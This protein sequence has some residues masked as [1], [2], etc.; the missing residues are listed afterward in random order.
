M[1]KQRMVAKKINETVIPAHTADGIKA[2]TYQYM[3]Q[4]VTG[5]TFYVE[6]VD[7]YGRTQLHGPF[8][9]GQ[10]HGQAI[11][12]DPIDWGSILFEHQTKEEA[13]R[14][15]AVANTQAQMHTTVGPVAHFNIT[16]DGLYRVSY[17]DLLNGGFDLSGVATADIAVT[18]WDIPVPLH[19]E[20]GATFEV[21]SYIEFYG[22]GV[23][24]TYTKENVYT[25]HIDSALANRVI[26]DST[27]P[28]GS[29]APFYMETLDLGMNRLYDV[30]SS[31]NTPWYDSRLVATSGEVARSFPFVVDHYVAGVA[32]STLSIDMWG[33]TQFEQSPD[34]HVVVDFGGTTLADVTFDGLT[35]HPLYMTL[36]D[37]LVQEGSN[38]LI[39]R[40]PHDQGVMWDV[41]GVTSYDLTYPRAF[42][43]QDE[44]ILIFQS[45]GDMFQIEDL[46]TD[47]V[48]VYRLHGRGLVPQMTRLEGVVI[49]GSSGDYQA[50]FP[51]TA[52]EDTYLVYATAHM[53][54]PAIE[55]V[56]AYTDITSGSAD[57]LMIAHPDFVNDLAPLVS[58]H[59]AQGLT[60]QVVDVMDIYDQFNG[61]VVD[62]WAIKEYIKY[63]AQNMGI[64]YV[65]LVGGDS[66]DYHNYLGTGA[67]SF[68]PTIYMRTGD[69]VKFAPT[70]PFY[71]DID[72]DLVPDLK[73]GRFPVR[74]S[75]ELGYVIQKTIT[76]QG[77][78][79][80]ETAI[81]AADATDGLVSFS[82]VSDQL[83][84]QLST[85]QVT[86]AYLDDM[87]VADAQTL[88]EDN[89]NNGVALVNFFGHSS[90]T[91]W[92][93][94]GL[95][96]ASD[97]ALLNN[98]NLPTV[99]AQWGCWNTYYVA[100]QYNTMGHQFMMAGEQG[101]A[102]V[103]GASTLTNATHEQ[104][105]GELVLARL[106][107]P[108]TTLGE[109]ITLAK[110]DLSA[111]NPG[112]IDV[113]MGYSLLG[114]PALAMSNGEPTAVAMHLT[115][116]Q[117]ARL[118]LIL[119]S[120]TILMVAV[121][122]MVLLTRRR[123]SIS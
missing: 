10:Q 2:N 37:G 68:I 3:A 53:H 66:Y 112:L 92:S 54:V 43:P 97:A 34:H 75:Q 41:V 118:P 62:A 80:G 114:D 86:N 33:G 83:A 27:S 49:T 59:E 39:M 77:I 6:D 26:V 4:D 109:A 70:D 46:P 15:T 7:L 35:S 94:L 40:L 28:V 1:L 96:Q 65:L 67:Y 119:F 111:Q 42:V 91:S 79:Y 69:I 16:Q 58:F 63:A 20:A 113:Q 60:V 101:A 30:A 32:D 104:W 116:I 107:Q 61:G 106:A 17:D 48:A 85:W 88:I 18:N 102:A 122:G 52:N 76:Y 55:P 21:G 29:P 84:E 9:L 57:Y 31:S 100:P 98:I 89:I 23:D 99:V 115:Q 12:E 72:N 25:L 50:T 121:T 11:I 105:L 120:I 56:R 95:F 81:L 82:H 36:P 110:A 74:T 8:T 71:A 22:R 47:N 108:G 14:A 90:L 38:S 19:I 93:P 123:R 117:S 51:G 103:L 24:T 44:G 64:E 13:R 45:A 87:P 78:S 73:L 5:D